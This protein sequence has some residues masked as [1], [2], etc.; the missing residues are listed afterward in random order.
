MK[1]I[2][3]S[4]QVGPYSM[5]TY[6]I[7]DSRKKVSAVIDPG[8]DPEKTL[9]MVAGTRIAKIL[10][11]HGH[12]DHTLALE[13]IEVASQA[14]IYLHPFDAEKFG[15]NEC[16]PLND[17]QE[18]SV[19]DIKLKVIHVPGHTPGQCCFNLG[20]GRIVVGDTIFVGGPGRTANTEDFSTTMRTMQDIVFN[21]PDDTKFYPG[22]GPEGLIGQE[23]P[24][25]E[26]F[27]ALGWSENTHGDIT[28][29]QG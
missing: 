18:I 13:A 4:K 2:L 25:F 7:I 29:T 27:L 8:G 21:W 1:P 15:I 6:A 17:G 9:K 11:T 14:P 5:N 10:L 19:G 3:L 23:R 20:D 26:S 12:S 28:W 22:H 24:D 16:N